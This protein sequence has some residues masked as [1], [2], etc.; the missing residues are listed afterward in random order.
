MADDDQGQQ[1]EEQPQSRAGRM[2]KVTSSTVDDDYAY[3]LK[4][5]KKPWDTS[6]QQGMNAQS[7]G[8]GAQFE[9]QKST[10]ASQY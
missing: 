2:P 7:G 4:A 10:T 6:A 3:E 9:I 1:Q 8:M 5:P